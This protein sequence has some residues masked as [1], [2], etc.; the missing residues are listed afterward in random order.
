MNCKFYK[1]EICTNIH[2]PTCTDYCPC[3]DYDN[4]CRYAEPKN[5]CQNC[6]H[7][8]LCLYNAYKSTY[9]KNSK[10]YP[11]KVEIKSNMCE[12]FRDKSE[13]IISPCKINS[14]FFVIPTE[15][16]GLEKITQMK[17]YG[18]ETT[19]THSVVICY[20]SKEV[21]QQ[22]NIPFSDF[23][24]IAFITYEKAEQ[25]LKKVKQFEAQKFS[26][27]LLTKRKGDY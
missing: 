16:N 2:S 17:A 22:Y 23:G 1:N 3:S 5:L 20:K 4:I 13:Y 26:L 19:E 25:A 21:S 11:I 10:N 7:Y 18:F 8:D 14:H 15:E 24:K 6:I 9:S 12:N 27:E